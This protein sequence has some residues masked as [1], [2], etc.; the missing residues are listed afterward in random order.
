[1]LGCCVIQYNKSAPATPYP[2]KKVRDRKPRSAVA[3][4]PTKNKWPG[5]QAD[6]F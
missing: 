3:P 5:R 2:A 1:M 4:G 6:E